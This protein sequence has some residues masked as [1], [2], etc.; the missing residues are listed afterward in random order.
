MKAIL[1]RTILI[2]AAMASAGFALGHS[3]ADFS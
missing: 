3:A 1:L 2:A